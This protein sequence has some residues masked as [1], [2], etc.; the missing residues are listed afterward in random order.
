MK[1]IAFMTI[2]VYNCIMGND[3]FERGVIMGFKD[4][5][6]KQLTAE[7]LIKNN[8]IIVM[9]V[10]VAFSIINLITKQFFAAGFIVVIGLLVIILQVTLKKRISQDARMLIIVNAQFLIIFLVSV[11]KGTVHEMFALY[12]ASCVMSAVYFKRRIIV[13]LGILMNVCLLGALPFAE[14]TYRGATTSALLK[15]FLALELGIVF[16]WLVVTWGNGFIEKAQES[17]ALSDNLVLDVQAKIKEAEQFNKQQELLFANVFQSATNVNN[18]SDKMTS[19]VTELHQGTE[20]Q[21]QA[22]DLMDNAVRELRNE[23]EHSNEVCR[24]S[25]KAT[26]TVSEQLVTGD[27]QMKLLVESMNE[28]NNTVAEIAKVLKT[29]DNIAF[30]T[31]I[32]A[33][34]ASVEAARAGAAG[35]GF[36]VVAEEVRRLA[37][38]SA[39]AASNTAGLM[40]RINEVTHNTIEITNQTA[41]SINTVMSSAELSSKGIDDILELA[42]R[43]IEYVGTLADDMN[44]ITAVVRQNTMLAEQSTNISNDLV[45]QSQALHSLVVSK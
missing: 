42:S 27:H 35:K 21:T 40:E 30:Q 19:V 22:V 32:L 14:F 28:I 34:N 24:Q 33:L 38:Q 5:K 39:E 13:Q 9:I 8:L 10:C 12:L 7:Q 15:D 36:S 20:S 31:N 26:I 44:N 45:M 23:I 4:K 18:I 1:I 29:I 16:V 11:F 6:L 2:K 3:N 17:A 37:A 41:K 25:R 43:Q